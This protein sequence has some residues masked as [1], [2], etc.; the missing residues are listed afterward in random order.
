MSFETALRA[1]LKADA[2]FAAATVEWD[3]RPEASAYPAVV[4]ETIAGQRDQTFR[5]L[6]QTNRDRIQFNVFAMDKATAVAL[7][8]AVI[9]IITTPVIVAGIEFQRGSLVM[10]RSDTDSTDDGTVRIEIVDAYLWHA[11]V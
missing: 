10:H 3:E 7:R 9:A 5:G 8:E 2:A 1:R 11:A 6:Q 4:L